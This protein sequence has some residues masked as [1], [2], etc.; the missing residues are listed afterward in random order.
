[1]YANKR[2]RQALSGSMCEVGESGMLRCVGRQRSGWQQNLGG[3]G[4][5]KSLKK[6]W[7]RVR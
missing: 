5:C 7:S 1:M 6:S 3:A 2:R 4:C